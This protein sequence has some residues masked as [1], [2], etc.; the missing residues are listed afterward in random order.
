[1]LLEKLTLTQLVK[2]FLASY[3]TRSFIAVFTT[4]HHWSLCW[5]MC[6]LFP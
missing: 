6:I 4:A 3:G 5:A 1:V 2:K